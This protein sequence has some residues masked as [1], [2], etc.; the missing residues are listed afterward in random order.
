MSQILYVRNVTHE[1][2]VDRMKSEFLSHAAHELRTPMASIFGFSEL[3]L[4]RDFDEETRRDLIETIYKQSTWLV[5]IINELLDLARIDSRRGKE[6]NIEAV[7]LAG[8]VA[9]VAEAHQI[10]ASRWPLSLDL[11]AGLPAARAD[12]AKLRQAL[13]NVLGNAVKYSPEGGAIEIACLT[14]AAGT[15]S[16]VGL[17]VTDHGI[18]LTREQAARIGERFYRADSSGNI[19]GTGL[20]M[21]IVKEIVEL[22]RGYFEIDSKPGC[23]TSVTLWLPVASSSTAAPAEVM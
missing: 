14:R 7:D 11:P 19:P 2:E 13:T 12:H 16:Y 18:G 23:G 4:S 1:V 15:A 6:F 17:R 20:G 9:E 3:L 5:E 21:S 8:L 10:D 22:L